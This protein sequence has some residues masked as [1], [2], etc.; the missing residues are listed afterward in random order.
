MTSAYKTALIVGAG[1]SLSAALAR[2]FVLERTQVALVGRARSSPNHKE[3]TTSSQRGNLK[4]L[5][6]AAGCLR[7]NR[8]T[9]PT[10]PGA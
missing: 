5:R 9:R 2:L 4:T 3:I 10:K 7:A 6:P 8:A 1:H